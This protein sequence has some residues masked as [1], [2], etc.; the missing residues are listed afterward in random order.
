MSTGAMASSASSTVEPGSGATPQ[1]RQVGG[2]NGRA[3]PQ[4]SVE[5]RELA[6]HDRAQQRGLAGTVRTDDP[7]AVAARRLQPADPDDRNALG[8]ARHRRKAGD[9]VFERDDHVAGPNGTASQQRRRAQRH[10]GLGARRG[11]AVLL[12]L[13]QPPL[14]LV[15]LRVLAMA[16]IALDE[17]EFAGRGL[18]SGVGVLALPRVA[19][20]A[21]HE[22][23]RV[24]A[25]KRRDVA[26]AQLPDA[27][28]H[29]V[30]EGAVV[31]RHEQARP[32]GGTAPLRATPAR[33]GPG[34][35]S[36]RPAA[37]GPDRTR[38]AAQA[39][40]ASAR[41]RRARGPLASSPRAECRGP[42]APRPPAGRG[43]SRRAS[44]SAR[45]GARIRPTA[46]P[47]RPGPRAPPSRR[48]SCSTSTAPDRTA[49]RT[50]GAAAKIA[51]RFASW[52]SSP[53]LTP[54]AVITRPPSGSWSPATISSSVVLPA[55]FGA[56]RA[57]RA[58]RA[59]RLR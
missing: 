47:R 39:R 28:H 56:D 40:S 24:R 7:D 50:W 44:R 15:H 12:E 48:S 53:T 55:P 3:E 5:R 38:A 35:W 16:A 57:R 20:L 41:R 23:G 27:R 22:V 19:L 52:L 1:L 4:E 25:A 45:A 58:R 37:A 21:L 43:G 13:L 42:R 9:H 51:S 17:L 54:V 29:G 32:C 14:V 8:L 10:A 36:A 18:C 59:R 46:P 33:R 26:V 49:R 2:L 6:R 31:G 30:Q 34:G 11:D